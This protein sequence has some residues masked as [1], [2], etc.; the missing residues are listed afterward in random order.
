VTLQN[1]EDGIFPVFEDTADRLLKVVGDQMDLV[2]EARNLTR[3]RV[4]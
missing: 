2:A 4:K 3:L 1:D